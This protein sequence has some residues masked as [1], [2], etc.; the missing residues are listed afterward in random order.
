[1]CIFKVYLINSDDDRFICIGVLYL[2]FFNR[3]GYICK[4]FILC[5]FCFV[6]R[7][8]IKKMF[9]NFYLFD[10]VYVEGLNKNCIKFM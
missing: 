3:L 2:F 10:L 8:L 4:K 9:F 7:N 1:M 6:F 5:Y